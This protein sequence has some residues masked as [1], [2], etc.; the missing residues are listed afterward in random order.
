[1]ASYYTNAPDAFPKRT[2]PRV[3]GVVLSQPIGARPAV[4]WVLRIV[5]VTLPLTAGPAVSAALRDW[6]DAPELVAEVLLWLSW[7]AGLLAVLAPRPMSLTAV[8]VIAPALTVV[9]LLAVIDGAPSALASVGAV[10]ATVVALVLVSSHDLALASANQLAYGDEQRVLLRTPPALFLGPL[11]MAR[12]LLAAAIGVP[13]LLLADEQWVIGVITLVLAV[14]AAV[15]LA[16]ALHGLSRRWGVLVP[17]GFVIV[18]PLTLTDPVLFLRERIMSMHAADAAPVPPDVLDL[19]LGA[20]A[21]SVT[22]VFDEAAEIGRRGR[23]RASE[24]V[25]VRELRFSVARRTAFLVAAGARRI[26]VT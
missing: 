19:R 6:A 22:L 9:A 2:A 23:R 14:P 10:V 13:P 17:A 16:R 8:R 1:M 15:V 25:A 24:T 5:W 26:R 18:D 7:A 11:P 3:N 20:G 4:L 12:L 21:G